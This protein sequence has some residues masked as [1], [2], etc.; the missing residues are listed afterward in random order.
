M[1]TYGLWGKRQQYLHYIYME[2]SLAGM[3]L[4]PNP[5]A[6]LFK[7]GEVTACMS[8]NYYE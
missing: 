3:Q 7:S 2:I 4:N 8:G 1:S 6:Q 5:L